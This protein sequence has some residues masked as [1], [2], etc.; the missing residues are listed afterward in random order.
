MV[1][2]P[3]YCE[4]AQVPAALESSFE[5]F[6]GEYLGKNLKNRFNDKT[7]SWIQKLSIEEEL[8][9]GFTELKGKPLKE[10]EQ[11]AYQRWQKSVK[12]LRDS[13]VHRG[14]FVN[15]S[16]AREVREVVFDLMTKIDPMIIDNFRI[17][18]EKIELDRPNIVFGTATIKAG[19]KS[20]TTTH[21]LGKVPKTIAITGARQGKD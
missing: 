15:E 9:P 1:L 19:S 3:I 14:T 11:N 2:S 4:P 18:F 13:V 6:I 21:N 8:K 17:Q 5:V 20:V 12:E 7:I 16:Q 10:I